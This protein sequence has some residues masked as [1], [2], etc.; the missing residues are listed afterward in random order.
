M[1]TETPVANQSGSDKPKNP[2]LAGRAAVDQAADHPDAI[3]PQ[4]AQ[5][6][7][8]W[9]LNPDDEESV[10]WATLPVNVAPAGKPE[11]VVPFKIQVV[12]RDEIKRLRKE[13]TF[14]R[15]DGTEEIDEMEAN[16]RIAVEGLLE[17]NVKDD[18]KLR[19]VRGQQYLDPGDALRARFAH[20]PGIIDQ[21]AGKIVQISGYNSADVKE[22]RAAGN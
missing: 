16:L 7:T 11:R 18:D 10:A 14:Q 13:A 15:P 19:V 20:K 22:V 3:S 1:A 9:F 5:S 4:T 17:P 8:D 2:D 6:A 12:D 21:I